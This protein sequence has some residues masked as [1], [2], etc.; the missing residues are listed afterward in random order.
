MSIAYTL[1]VAGLKAM[2]RGLIRPLVGGASE[3]CACA[4]Q[5]SAP[6]PPAIIKP[7]IMARAAA[8]SRAVT[9]WESMRYFTL[10]TKYLTGVGQRKG[11]LTKVPSIAK[12]HPDLIPHAR[13]SQDELCAL[14]ISCWARFTGCC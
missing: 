4:G 14:R 13:E 9:D 3:G 11:N 5:D 1:P 8:R 7:G 10:I 2:A 12:P 6:M